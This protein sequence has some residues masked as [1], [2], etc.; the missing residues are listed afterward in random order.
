MT[1]PDRPD[2]ENAATPESVTFMGCSP[3]ASAEG[4]PGQKLSHF[5]LGDWRKEKNYNASLVRR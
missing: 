2:A 1:Q 5:D 3:E 4:P